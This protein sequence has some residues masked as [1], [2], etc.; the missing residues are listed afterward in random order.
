MRDRGRDREREKAKERAKE[1]T[2]AT[3]IETERDIVVVVVFSLGGVLFSRLKM[4]KTIQRDT[5]SIAHGKEKM[6][7]VFIFLLLSLFSLVRLP[8]K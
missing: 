3:G 8:L 4:Q 2:I 7:L 6:V 1:R 5:R